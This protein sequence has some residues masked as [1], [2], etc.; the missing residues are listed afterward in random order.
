M[1]VS[2]YNELT[3]AK[4]QIQATHQLVGKNLNRLEMKGNELR[5]TL[6]ERLKSKLAEEELFYSEDEEDS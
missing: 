1:V 4:S 5:K 2:N 3:D 6:V